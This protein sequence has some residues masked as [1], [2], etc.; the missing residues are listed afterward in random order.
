MGRRL[1]MSSRNATVHRQTECD[2]ERLF[3]RERSAHDKLAELD[4]RKDEFLAILGHELRNPLSSILG[5]MQVLEQPSCDKPVASEMHAVIKRQSLHMVRLIEDLSDISRIGCGRVLLQMKR[6]DLAALT[7]NTAT[8]YRHHL[9]KNQLTLVLRLPEAPIWVLGDAVRLSQVITNLLH[10]AAK[11]TD[12]GGTVAV[13]LV[14]KNTLAVL[15]VRDNGIGIEPLELSSVFEPFHQV[16]SRRARSEGGFG[17]G[18]ALSERLVR[19]HAGVITVA[20]EGLGKGTLFSILLP[21]A[22]DA[23]Q[24]R[25]N[26]VKDTQSADECQ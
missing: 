2:W 14:R 15:S 8:D 4:R 5:A 22:T 17:L 1:S 24:P 12:S 6:I 18:L 26:S 11:F 19:Q 23:C 7:R 20:S 13:E 3:N 16:E 10:N 25:S 9:D 21:L